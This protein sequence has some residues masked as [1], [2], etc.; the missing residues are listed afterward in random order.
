MHFKPFQA[1]LDHV[2]LPTFL[3][4]YAREKFKKKLKKHDLKWLKMA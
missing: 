2:F 3:S 4:G 1:I